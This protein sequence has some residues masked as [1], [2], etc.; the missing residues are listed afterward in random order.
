MKNLTQMEVVALL[1]GDREAQNRLYAYVTSYARVQCF[2]KGYKD[3]FSDQDLD[4]I[5]NIAYFKIIKGLHT[6]KTDKS[7]SKWAR[8][9][10][11]NAMKDY[12]DDRMDSL[13]HTNHVDNYDALAYGSE[14]DNTTPCYDGDVMKPVIYDGFSG[15]MSADADEELA[16]LELE[17]KVKDILTER[18]FRVFMMYANDCDYK[19]IAH[20]IG[21]SVGNARTICS[22]AKGMLREKLAA[23]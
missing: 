8:S 1:Q 18:D 16:Y 6:Y 7:F 11:H 3:Y 23:A 17:S 20:E 10:I 22:R 21:V 13:Q 5:A 14:A 2:K 9:V 12:L 4:D 15:P 19:E